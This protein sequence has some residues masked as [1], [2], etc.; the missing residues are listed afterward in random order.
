MTELIKKRTDYIEWNE[1]F[2]A[3]ALLS[4]K[5]SKDPNT[6]VGACITNSDHKITAVGYNGLPI[7]CSDDTFPWGKNTEN[8]LDNKHMYV[9]HAEL[10]AILSKN[11]ADVKNGTMY[12]TL[13]PCNE[14]TKLIIQSQI[15]EIIYLSDKH[16]HKPAV[17]AAKK[18]FDTVGISYAK[19]VPKRSTIFIDFMPAA[20]ADVNELCFD[21]LQL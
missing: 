18:M 6:Q 8:P 3:I 9:C 5:R 12:V 16:S 7:G 21:K 20:A 13:F 14:C 19:F 2:M 11:S 15:K 1:Y 17:I 4:A 10:N